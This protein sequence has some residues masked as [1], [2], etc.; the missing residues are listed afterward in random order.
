VSRVALCVQNLP[1][2]ADR[3]VWRE[4]CA[5]RDAGHDVSVV[6]PRGAEQPRHEVL[7]GITVRRWEPARERGG[8]IGQVSEALTGLA[9]TGREL[10]EL[11]RVRGLDV[12]HVANPPDG[13]AILARA[14]HREWK[15][16]F[17]QH[18]LCPELLDAQRGARSLVARV[19]RPIL[20]RME[21][22][23]YRCADLVILP[24][25]SYRAIALERGRV[26]PAA[27]V[28][29]RSGPDRVDPAP[30][31][32]E[33]SRPT[34]EVVFAGMMNVQ[35]RVDVLLSAVADVARR[36]PGCL[37]LTLVGTGDDVPRLRGLADA[38]GIAHLVRWTGWL[39]ADDLRA[40]LHR[41]DVGVSLDDDTPFSRLSTM[42]KIAEYLAV[43]LPCLVADLP[44]NRFTA[45]DAARYFAPADAHDL[46]AG[47]VTLL[48]DPLAIESMRTAALGRAPS[49]V[50]ERSARRLVAAYEWLLE[51][52]P[53]VAGDQ[54]IDVSVEVA[55]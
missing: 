53:A 27:A 11:Q 54:H 2:P 49:L 10:R 15:V 1:V 5:L 29:V 26:S 51:H 41:A 32:R 36:R 39:D 42:T 31:R 7:D 40:E 6:A 46:A 22:W 38:L 35:D 18:D 14:L 34:L 43:G 13:Y 44:E 50:W 19:L 33:R 25:N 55:A 45:G 23:S 52:A 9:R 21:Q 4:A 24:N 8:V 30:D 3:R 28:V 17:D 37:G 47:F 20:R 12:V 48:D 16:V